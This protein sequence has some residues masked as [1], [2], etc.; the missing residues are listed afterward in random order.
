MQVS[1]LCLKHFGKEPRSWEEFQRL[2]AM[3]LW[4]ED[5]ERE[6]LENLFGAGE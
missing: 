3:V 4:L 5:K 6:L 1:A 2:G